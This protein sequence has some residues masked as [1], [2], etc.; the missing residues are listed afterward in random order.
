M[1]PQPPCCHPPPCPARGQG[2][3][4]NMRV[5]SPAEPR[6]RCTTCG[7][8]F[9]ATQDTPCSRWRPAAEVVTRGLT[10]LRHGCPTQAIVAA[11][12]VEERTVAAWLT[13]AGQPGE[14]VHQHVVQQGWVDVPHVHADEL[15]VTLVGRRGWRA[16]AR[17]VPARR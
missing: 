4:R 10:R 11:F 6:D 12:G 3:Q 5:P 1:N 17:A 8:T 13:R 9:A 15:W 7:Q 14:R 2:G 16:L